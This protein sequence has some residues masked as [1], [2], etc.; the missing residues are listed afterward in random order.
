MCALLPVLACACSLE[1]LSAA[2]DTSSASAGGAGVS[3]GAGA[4]GGAG[5][6]GAGA[7]G[8]GGATGDVLKR[9]AEACELTGSFIKV[10]D[11]LADGGYYVVVPESAGCDDDR[12]SCSF[13][14]SEAGTYQI[15]VRVAAGPSESTD[16]SF[17]VR[18]DQAPPPGYQY[19]FIGTDFHLDYVN[20][21]DA[22][23]GMMLTFALE[24]GSHLVSF[25]C[26]EDGSRLDWVELVRIGP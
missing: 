2:W 25:A 10:E 7:A 21:S 15:K 11:E 24:P 5:G 19:N 1:G 18:V 16:N 13:K 12:V 6:G 26:R 23:K 4:T 22:E 9:E 17:L 8:G 3:S 20:D 14:I